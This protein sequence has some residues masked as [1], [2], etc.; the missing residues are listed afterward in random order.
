MILAV[1]QARMSSSRLP[2]KVMADVAGQPMIT[3]QVERLRR[4]RTLDRLVVATSDLLGDDGLAAYCSELGLAVH[5]GSL[6][7]VLD[8]FHGAVQAFG[9]ARAVIRLTADCPL[10]DWRVVDQVVEAHLAG[11]Y[12]YTN[13]TAP[14][15]TFPHGLDVEVATPKALEAAWREARDPYEREHVTPFL[16]RRPERFHLGSVKSDHPAPQLRWTVDAPQDLDFVRQVYETLYAANPAFT[17][18]DVAAL[19]CNSSPYEG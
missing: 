3:R 12:D 6:D 1:L 5:R 16:Y 4:A 7:D 19:P 10:A 2:G 8:R 13:N 18:E 9:P 14:K 11:G 17:S 15:R